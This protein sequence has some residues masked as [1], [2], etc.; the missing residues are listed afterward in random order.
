MLYE[1]EVAVFSE[2]NTKQINSVWAECQFSSF[3]PAGTRYQK[4]LKS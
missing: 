3:K 2:I 4:A 1:A